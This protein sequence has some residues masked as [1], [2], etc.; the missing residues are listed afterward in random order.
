M[1]GKPTIHVVGVN[2]PTG[3]GRV[4]SPVKKVHTSG[5]R[6]IAQAGW[7]YDL[8]GAPA[9]H[10]DGLVI[11]DDWATTWDARVLEDVTSTLMGWQGWRGVPAAYLSAFV[12]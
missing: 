5:L 1:L 10:A 3:R 11:L 8:V 4:S 7:L 9:S 6:G 2:C 12:H